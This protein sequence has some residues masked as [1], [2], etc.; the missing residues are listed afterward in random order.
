MKKVM[1]AKKKSST[2][3]YYDHDIIC[4]TNQFMKKDG[5]IKIP[6]SATSLEYFCSHGLK[7][8]IKFPSAMSE[9]EIMKEIQFV[10]SRAFKSESFAFEILQPG[11]GVWLYRLCL[12]CM[13]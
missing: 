6:R 7:V 8:K 10:F 4:L 3:V 5:T 1:I 9:S 11:G 2:V 12:L 13:F